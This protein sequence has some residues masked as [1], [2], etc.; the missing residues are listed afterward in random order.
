MQIG[1]IISFDIQSVAIQLYSLGFDFIFIDL[2]HGNVSDTVIS[3][4]IQSKKQSNKVYIRIN[5]I[6]EACIKHAFDLGCDGIIAPRVEVIDELKTLIKY[7]YYHPVGER[8]VGFCAANKFGLEFKNNMNNFKPE[9]FVQIESKKGIEIIDDII[10][11]KYISGVFLGPYDLSMSLGVAGQ[12]NSDTFIDAYHFVKQKCK[13]NNKQFGTFISNNS[14]NIDKEID[15][16]TIGVDT[17][18]ILNMY[19][20]II[21]PDNS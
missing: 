16:L 1:T 4:I 6:N 2:E 15:L 14:K 17:N 21:N 5:K 7:S 9:I 13:N 18:L 3:A 10:D 20:D 8:S 19:S 12:F 11:N